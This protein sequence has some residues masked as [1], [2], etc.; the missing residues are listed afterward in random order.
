MVENQIILPPH[1]P[2]MCKHKHQTFSCS[3]TKDKLE[4]K[5]RLPL[6][7]WK[8][9]R[10]QLCSAWGAASRLHGWEAVHLHCTP[11]SAPDLLGGLGHTPLTQVFKTV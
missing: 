7:L 2:Q 6:P 4:E 11:G 3:L 10:V 9:R 5:S 8:W 1:P